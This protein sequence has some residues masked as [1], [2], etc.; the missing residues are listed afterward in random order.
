MTARHPK[1]GF[2][3]LLALFL[4]LTLF[5]C[6]SSDGS[7]QVKREQSLGSENVAV[8]SIVFSADGKSL[9]FSG[10][11][12]TVQSTVEI[13]RKSDQTWS[14]P[15]TLYESGR[16]LSVAISTDSK[17][18][19][20]GDQRGEITVWHLEDPATPA[21]LVPGVCGTTDTK[22]VDSVAF[23]PATNTLAVGCFNGAITLVDLST[24]DPTQISLSKKN[25]TQV[26]LMAFSAD[27]NM[28]AVDTGNNIISIWD[29][30]HP[31]NTPVKL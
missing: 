24:P 19:A 12:T 14:A 16:V 4:V 5:A 20:S 1:T 8:M 18:V 17:L 25:G 30:Q 7:L 23:R 9:L 27:G 28:L 22:W 11:S 3:Y 6:D 26:S 15:E 13:S 29:M 10:L 2:S 31:E 21:K